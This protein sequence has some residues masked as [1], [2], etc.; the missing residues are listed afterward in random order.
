MSDDHVRVVRTLTNLYIFF[1]YFFKVYHNPQ[2]EPLFRTLSY[3]SP[4]LHQQG[5]KLR[6]Y[7]YITCRNLLYD[8]THART[9][10]TH[11]RR[12]SIRGPLCRGICRPWLWLILQVRNGLHHI[13]WQKLVFDEADSL[14]RAANGDFHQDFAQNSYCRSSAIILHYFNHSILIL[15]VYMHANNAIA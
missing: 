7:P 13:V 1:F 10:T 5:S 6:Y 8:V 11:A 12:S 15:F 4:K 9:Y 3:L 14:R 2:C